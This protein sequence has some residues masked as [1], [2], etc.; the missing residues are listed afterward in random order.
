MPPRPH[1]ILQLQRHLRGAGHGE[2]D[3]SETPEVRRVKPTRIV[4]ASQRM[5]EEEVTEMASSDEGELEALGGRSSW[6]LAVPQGTGVCERVWEET[7]GGACIP[8]IR[9]FF[10]L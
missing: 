4:V 1:A 6:S 10:S 8:L 3:G 9:L 7:H 5:V 2:E